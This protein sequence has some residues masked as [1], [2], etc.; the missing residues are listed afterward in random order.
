MQMRFQ[1]LNYIG[2]WGGLQTES[3]R[4]SVLILLGHGI[5]IPNVRFCYVQSR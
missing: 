2:A 5:Y 3:G 4:T 1:E